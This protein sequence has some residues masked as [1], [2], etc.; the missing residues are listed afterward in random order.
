[1]FGNS[2]DY[3]VIRVGEVMAMVKGSNEKMERDR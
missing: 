1:M 2:S 3:G